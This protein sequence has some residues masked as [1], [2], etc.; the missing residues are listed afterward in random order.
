MTRMTTAAMIQRRRRG[1]RTRDL[2]H[3]T[4]GTHGSSL[5]G[6]AAPEGIDTR[7]A[8][9]DAD[10][11]WG[12][13][14]RAAGIRS[15]RCPRN[16]GRGRRLRTG[17]GHPL[18]LARPVA[19]DR[20]HGAGGE[21][22]HHVIAGQALDS[23][24][25]PLPE[26]RPDVLDHHRLLR[27][28]QTRLVVGAAAGAA[29]RPP[30]R[31]ARGRSHQH[32]VR[33]RCRS[34]VGERT[35]ASAACSSAGGRRWRSESTCSASSG[36]SSTDHV[37]PWDRRL[38]SSSFWLSC[39][40]RLSRRASAV[41]MGAMSSSRRTAAGSG[42]SGGRSSAGIVR[43]P[44][45]SVDGRSPRP[46]SA[47]ARG[48]RPGLRAPPAADPAAASSP[49][50]PG[51]G[52]R[53]STG[54]SSP[55]GGRILA[56]RCV[57]LATVGARRPATLQPRRPASSSAPLL[58]T[59]GS[60]T[61]SGS[62]ASTAASAIGL[63]GQQQRG[64]LLGRALVGSVRRLPSGGF[65][66]QPGVVLGGE[67]VLGDGVDRA[68][69]VLDR[70]GQPLATGPQLLDLGVEHL[71]ALGQ[72]GQHPGPEALGL[73]DHRPALLAGLG[74]QLLGLGP[75]R[76]EPGGDLLVGPLA[77]LVGGGLG[78]PSACSA[79]RDSVSAPALLDLSVASVSS[80]FGL[81]LR[82]GHHLGGHLVG[83]VEHPGR[84]GAHR[85]GQRRLV[86][87]GIGRPV[88]GIGRA[89]G[90]ARAP[91]RRSPADPRRWT[92]GRHGPRRGRSPG[93]PSRTCAGPHR[94][95][96]GGKRR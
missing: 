46:E 5:G 73:L 90:A 52:E 69:H 84:L 50:T 31:P 58:G 12:T 91:A 36:S 62:P 61:A 9:A 22:R 23:L 34:G 59:A 66:R 41:T 86:E 68:A 2:R 48:R 72:I 3:V 18:Q 95:G 93:A 28:V 70:L 65:S 37:E 74:E 56:N 26:G 1:D 55:T 33:G 77:Q 83:A 17:H 19:L 27:L 67:Q 87:H 20:G 14:R 11:R 40:V 42:S 76:L 4:R 63:L 13:P 24:A 15:A 45:A 38:S 44:G 16:R 43:R 94:R 47:R 39:R 29:G 71:P 30:P 96:P 60:S 89:P 21:R 85:R 8:P 49:S 6:G 64:H 35:P 80:R 88:L 81:G 32:I 54:S 10:A 53:C 7:G 82:L 57:D 79:S 75:G 92:R 25:L 51:S 78:S